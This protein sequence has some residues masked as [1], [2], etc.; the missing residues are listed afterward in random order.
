MLT[1]IQVVT[2]AAT[3]A[4]S[5]LLAAAPAVTARPMVIPMPGELFL[6]D[7]ERSLVAR[8]MTPNERRVIGPLL[9]DD[10]QLVVAYSRRQYR[11]VVGPDGRP[12]PEPVGSIRESP[13]SP[14]SLPSVAVASSV[15]KPGTD[16][17]ISFS[18]IRTRSSSPYEW[19]V[20]PYFEWRGD[21]GMN[22]GNS[23]ADSMAV[24]WAGNDTYLHRQSGSGQ[25]KPGWPCNASP[26]DIWPS[27]GTPNAGTA[28]S[29]HEWGYWWGCS[30]W[31]GWADIRLRQQGWKARTDNVV[32]RYYH[33]YGGLDY[34][35]NFSKTPGITISPT[36]E[37][38]SLT[39]FETYRH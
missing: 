22:R 9:E 18:V 3:L 15:T 29:F 37:Q 24:A 34:S 17:Y 33:T 16:L 26:I 19:Q 20:A 25:Q 39:L 7:A 13:A 14:L 2:L 23:S 11:V 31:W 10:G 38:W 36:A 27:D 28:W 6:T 35:F 1:R 8:S 5:A 4:A 32:Y 21:D 30:A 12:R